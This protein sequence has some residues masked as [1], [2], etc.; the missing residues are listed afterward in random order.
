M[1]PSNSAIFD[2]QVISAILQSSCFFFSSY[3]RREYEGFRFLYPFSSIYS[4]KEVV[5]V[6]ALA[7]IIAM[8]IEIIL[9]VRTVGFAIYKRR[10]IY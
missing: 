4:E 6:I 2:H 1:K 8:I 5:I 3:D 7:S 9:Q 10:D